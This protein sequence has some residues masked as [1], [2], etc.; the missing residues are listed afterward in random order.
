MWNPLSWVMEAAAI[1]AIS[2]ANGG[3][4][5]FVFLFYYYYCHKYAL[6]FLVIKFDGIEYT[7]NVNDIMF[8]LIKWNI[9]CVCFIIFFVFSTIN[10]QVLYFQGKSPD[11]QEFVGIIIL[12]LINS[13]IS[14]IEEKNASNAAA[15]LMAILA[16]KAK[17]C[18]TN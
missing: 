18:W 15:A 7:S 5:L 3:V 8:T 10:I 9:N 12:I 14:F 13:S 4:C 6:F 11:W 1:M 17:V 16:P 2:L